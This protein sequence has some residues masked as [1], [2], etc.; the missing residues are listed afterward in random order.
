MVGWLTAGKLSAGGIHRIPGL[1]LKTIR[2]SS[3][4]CCRSEQ[5]CPINKRNI[6]LVK[7]QHRFQIVFADL[8]EMKLDIVSPEFC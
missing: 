6:V 3:S 7:T 2:D 5:N 1:N 4:R 8:I